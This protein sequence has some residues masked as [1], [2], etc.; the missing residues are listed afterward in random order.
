M[1][2]KLLLFTF[3]CLFLSCTTVF[4]QDDTSF[5]EYFIDLKN[6]TIKCDIRVNFTFKNLKLKYKSRS[7]KDYKTYSLDSLKALFTS[8]DSS[9][10]A[11]KV[12]PKT[13]ELNLLKVLEQGKINLYQLSRAGSGSKLYGTTFWY[14]GKDQDSLK[15]IKFVSSSIFKYPETIGSRQDREKAFLDAIADNP[16]L[17]VRFEEATKSADYSFELIRYYIKT[18]NDEYLENHK[19][20][21]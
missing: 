19:I 7:D 21:K 15:Q 16:G 1:K 12:L 10:F 9:T 13:G 11:P 18:Y 20:P 6:D 5:G 17:L 3:F 8:G 4:A 14:V 2:I